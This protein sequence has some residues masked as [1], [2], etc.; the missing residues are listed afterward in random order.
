MFLYSNNLL[1]LL[2]DKPGP[3]PL[4]LVPWA[5]KHTGQFRPQPSSGL[6]RKSSEERALTLLCKQE[7]VLPTPLALGYSQESRL[8]WCVF[9]GAHEDPSIYKMA[10][11]S[12]ALAGDSSHLIRH[13]QALS[14]YAS[15]YPSLCA[16]TRSQVSTSG[17]YCSPLFALRQGLPPNLFEWTGWQESPR[18]LPVPTSLVLR[19]PVHTAQSHSGA[20]D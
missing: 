18:G 5:P 1:F 13:T 17:V 12:T 14:A 11:P 3:Q 15:S 2:S 10:T 9:R 4:L 6:E 16:C 20:G 8:S 7:R 19:S